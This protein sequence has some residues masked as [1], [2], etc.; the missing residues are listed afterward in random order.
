MKGKTALFLCCVALAGLLGC[1]GALPPPIVLITIDTL[2]SDHL[3][4]YGYFRPTSPVIDA[5][6]AESV[7]FTNVVSTMATTLPAHVSLFT[8]RYPIETGITANGRRLLG[9]ESGKN[10]RLLAQMLRDLGY[11]TAAFVSATP[12]KS[13][14]GID[15]GFDLFEQPAVG[16]R[17]ARE[18]TDRVLEWLEG[19][20]SER[21]FFLW[22]HYFDPHKPY[23]PPQP[24]RDVFAA[25]ERLVEFLE[26][27]G[28]PEPRDPRILRVN[29]LYDGEILST[30]TE[31]G[32]LV[33][34]LK[35]RGLFAETAM[36]VT[37]DHGE[38][39]GQHDRIGHGTIH[40]EQLFVPLLIRFPDRLAVEPRR[41]ERL[42][43]L[44][45]VLPTLAAGLR[46]PLAED[47]KSRFT[48][49][50]ALADT[51]PRTEAL[52]Q[53][54]TVRDAERL[55][56][57]GQREKFALLSLDWKYFYSTRRPDELFD[58]RADRH[59]LADRIADEPAT[60]AEMKNRLLAEIARRSRGGP[61][62][63]VVDETLPNVLEELKSLGYVQ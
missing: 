53:R 12:V 26:G 28:V 19:R 35:E 31:I 13:R 38:G 27:L 48:G 30:D 4:C 39:L 58:M 34:R 14:T 41:I 46:L 51:E 62:F 8:S 6:A 18:T 9:A 52:A 23:D 3:G 22:I 5:L 59:E 43:S 36:V 40:N 49:L 20:S 55:A 7:L 42:V 24:Y 61:D 25:D 60:A 47:D 37:S 33:D 15:A 16:G 45:D 63:E 10:T 54:S 44:I 21:P 1:R 57:R 17:K 32:R 56:K 11:E 29:D 50:D 2:R